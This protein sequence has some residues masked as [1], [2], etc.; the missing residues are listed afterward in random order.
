LFLALALLFPCLHVS[1][2]VAVLLLG[3][4]LLFRLQQLLRLCC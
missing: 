3:M 1:A 4:L 2:A